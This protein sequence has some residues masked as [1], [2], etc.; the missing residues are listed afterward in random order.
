MKV[1]TRVMVGNSLWLA[2]DQSEC[3]EMIEGIGDLATEQALHTIAAGP[4][5][6]PGNW[7]YYPAQRPRPRTHYLR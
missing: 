1:D 7:Q 5:W 3:R 6:F 4:G 2:C